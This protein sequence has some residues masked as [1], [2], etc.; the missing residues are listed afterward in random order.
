METLQ[1][2]IYDMLVAG[3]YGQQIATALQV[4]NKTVSL[5]IKAMLLAGLLQEDVYTSHRIYKVVAEYQEVKLGKPLGKPMGKTITTSRIGYEQQGKPTIEEA[6]QA[7]QPSSV[8]SSVPSQRLHRHY[9][10]YTLLGAEELQGSV[11]LPLNNNQQQLA[12]VLG[13]TARRTTKHLIIEGLQLF[14]QLGVI[15]PQL[16]QEAD[17]LADAIAE[18]VAVEHGLKLQRNANG[19]L[20]GITKLTEIEIQRHS[21]AEQVKE[22]GI[23]PLYWATYTDKEGQQHEEVALWTDKSFGLDNVE[24]ILKYGQYI[25]KFRQFTKDF[26]EGRWD[27]KEEHELLLATVKAAATTQ[28]QLNYYAEQ[29]AAHSAAIVKLNSAV[30]RWQV[31]MGNLQLHPANSQSLW[32]KIKR[33]FT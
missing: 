17:R 14:A 20:F 8:P 27:Y 18:V 13:A 9:R 33:L 2:K 16:A 26:M 31:L 24:G 1:R 32:E 29:V 4:S 28:G 22:K 25:D 23:I 3:K 19:G 11:P 21:M 15:V 7:V 6:S 12:R 5:H 10:E 30:D